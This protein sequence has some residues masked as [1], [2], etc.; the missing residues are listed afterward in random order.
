MGGSS[1]PADFKSV[2]GAYTLYLGNNG[3]N[4][5]NRNGHR[6]PRHFDKPEPT[7]TQNQAVLALLTQGQDVLNMIL[8]PSGGFFFALNGKKV[9]DVDK[10]GIAFG[11][12]GTKY[13]LPQLKKLAEVAVAKLSDGEKMTKAKYFAAMNSSTT[14]NNS[15]NIDWARHPPQ[16]RYPP[17]NASISMEV[18]FFTIS[19]TA[20]NDSQ[21]AA[22][23]KLPLPL[24]GMGLNT[25]IHIPQ[26]TSKQI[27]LDQASMNDPNASVRLLSLPRLGAIT[28]CNNET[29]SVG[30]AIP[31]RCIIFSSVPGQSNA[32][33]PLS[34]KYAILERQEPYATIHFG[35]LNGLSNASIDVFVDATKSKMKDLPVQTS[36]IL[37]PPYSFFSRA[38]YH[39]QAFFTFALESTLPDDETIF[40][41]VVQSALMG[42]R[43][44]TTNDFLSS[45]LVRDY[46]PFDKHLNAVCLARDNGST[47]VSFELLGVNQDPTRLAFR[48]TL[49]QISNALSNISLDNWRH[50]PHN[51]TI[52]LKIE[53]LSNTTT[54]KPLDH[55]IKVYF[56][57][58]NPSN[59]TSCTNLFGILPLCSESFSNGSVLASLVLIGI[60]SIIC[61][62]KK[63]KVAHQVKKLRAMY[64]VAN[65]DEFNGILDQ[66]LRVVLEPNLQAA[67]IL[68][69]LSRGC[70]EQ[71]LCIETL[72]L[73]LSFNQMMPIFL[74][75]LWRKAM[76]DE[77]DALMS[78]TRFYF[79]FIGQSW[80]CQV[81][82]DTIVQQDNLTT[83]LQHNI[84][85]YIDSLP[86]EIILLTEVIVQEWRSSSPANAFMNLL[87]APAL[88]SMDIA[89][90]CSVSDDLHHAFA[91]RSHEFY[92][93]EPREANFCVLHG[94][95]MEYI[96]LHLHC[97]CAHHVDMIAQELNVPLDEEAPAVGTRIQEIILA[98][99]PPAFDL[100]TLLRL[101]RDGAQ[102]S[103]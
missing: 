83:I 31:D 29:I 1:I 70:P 90:E 32:N 62:S 25:E 78:F 69:E 16:M 42:G 12:N 2:N 38:K 58:E 53:A 79:K 59:S 61:K 40:R 34:N 14:V 24:V 93:P 95:L 91:R 67:T 74:G 89:I 5:I 39:E 3:R 7:S 80:V 18:F 96:L 101:T 37:A 81:L 43:L 60:A 46:C 65:E 27:W 63:R 47:G 88:A 68:W 52:S 30:E 98:L 72:C 10:N 86:L 97:L 76:M 45:T 49:N 92:A 28:S 33:M 21:L 35:L 20:M 17:P 15:V 85:K 4:P 26:D 57:H 64:M 77:Y 41:V 6:L 84:I 50:Q 66:L 87:I 94:E 71:Q 51:A 11:N 23:A 56:T 103:T 9:V 75:K 8:P 22:R 99:G 19:Q 100:N 13:G 55:K 48:G 82:Q 73:A 102:L 36:L 54:I 44:N